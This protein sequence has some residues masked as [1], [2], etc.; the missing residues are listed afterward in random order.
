MID[1]NFF[2]NMEIEIGGLASGLGRGKTVV[3][4][5][6]QI[7]DYIRSLPLGAQISVRKIARVLHV[8]EGTAYRAIKDAERE[9][10]VSTLD[11]IGTVR[12]ERK[13]KAQIERLTFAEVVRIVEGTVLGGREG[14]H[15]SLGRLVIGAMKTESISRYLNPGSLMIVGNR[16]QV[17]R[18]SLKSGAAVLITGGF[19]ASPMV[20]RLANEYQLP[21]ISCSYDTF[22]TATLINRALYDQMI[23]K[24]IL[25]VEDV[26]QE[27]SL[28]TLTPVDTVR[29][30]YHLVEATGHSRVPV[31]DRN[32]RLVGIISPRD[33]A[34]AES[35]APIARFMTR[36]PVTVTPKTTI[37]SASHRMAFEGIEMMPVVRDRNLVGVL[38]RQDVIRA[39]QIM[40]R[41]PQVAETVEDVVVRDFASVESGDGQVL[42][43]GQVTPQ[44]TTS[45]GTLASG[46]LT[47]I[48]Q[49]A[50]RV[51]L[52]RV[53]H[54]D[55]VVE[56]M[57]LYM[58]R[59]VP[60]DSTIDARAQVLDYGRR[61]AKV[62]VVIEDEAD[63]F[64]KALLTAQWIER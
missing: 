52:R 53:R 14:L 47:T 31:V 59:P 64:A 42:L 10:F 25:Y 30:Y 60:V 6:Q 58:L 7:L 23:K 15:K 55:M 19:T 5:H 34:E 49:E 16:E 12:V 22:T 44:M 26:V 36:H 32:G 40:S 9:G 63:A 20:E 46:P 1:A 38:T 48:I 51:C 28:S 57:T 17:Q 29:D 62:E 3:T 11:R 45:G 56:N 33:V 50:A 24:D 54:A 8:S 18:M 43:R 35:S 39:L 61:Y 13:E 37:A 41:Q 27:Q 4:K 2:G 21:L